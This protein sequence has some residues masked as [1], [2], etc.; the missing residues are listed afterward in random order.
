MPFKHS[1][2]SAR[3][4][5]CRQQ[6]VPYIVLEVEKLM[7]PNLLFVRGTT[8]VLLTYIQAYVKIT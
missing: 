4:S 7:S 1:K 5:D 2:T 8:Q 6:T 3:L